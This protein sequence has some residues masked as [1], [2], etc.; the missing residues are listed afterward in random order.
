MPK[1]LSPPRH[2]NR[3]VLG[4]YTFRD[5]GPVGGQLRPLHD[6]DAAGLDEDDDGEPLAPEAGRG[7]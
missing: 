6:P 7:R 1:S 5:S 4:R 3:N 2:A